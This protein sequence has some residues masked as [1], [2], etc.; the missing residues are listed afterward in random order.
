M[1]NNHLQLHDLAKRRWL[2]ALCACVGLYVL[3][4]F[5]IWP[6]LSR[7]AFRGGPAALFVITAWLTVSLSCAAWTRPTRTQ[8]IVILIIF[9]S[10][11]L[12][13]V[14]WGDLGDAPIGLASSFWFPIHYTWH[15]TR[16]PAAWTAI[17]SMALWLVIFS[18]LA[19]PLESLSRF[20]RRQIRGAHG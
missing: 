20:L 6:L 1:T 13:A 3:M 19:W 8:L 15:D 10:W 17:H 14:V 18:F 12:G 11:S 4:L 7:T 2:F 16:A 9:A 5:A